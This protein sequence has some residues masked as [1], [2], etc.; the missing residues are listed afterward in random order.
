LHKNHPVSRSG[1]HPSFV[2]RGVFSLLT[3]LVPPKFGFNSLEDSSF[4][5]KDALVLKADHPN[6]VTLEVASPFGVVRYGWECE[7]SFTI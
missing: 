1:C 5:L 2:R 4:T 7:V 3:S 6:T